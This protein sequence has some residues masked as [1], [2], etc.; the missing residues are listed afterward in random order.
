M[1]KGYLLIFDEAEPALGWRL[2]W[3][4]L[5]GPLLYYASGKFADVQVRLQP[6]VRA[7]QGSPRAPLG[8]PSGSP[9]SLGAWCC[10]Q[11]TPSHDSRDYADYVS[12]AGSSYAPCSEPHV[13][14]PQVSAA[15]R[16][17]GSLT[18]GV[19]SAR[20][21]G[22]HSAAWRG[23]RSYSRLMG[24]QWQYEDPPR[25]NAPCAADQPSPAKPSLFG[26]MPCH[27]NAT[28]APAPSDRADRAG[29]RVGAFAW[30]PLFCCS[31]ARH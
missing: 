18:V 11:F 28:R 26:A 27:R 12:P 9:C 25:I 5:R 13:P 6:S 30:L 17:H 29:W 7:S 24:A 23:V 3:A 4:S 1:K 31:S 15:N 20:A 22:D 14:A 19:L 10:V 2:V 8:L 21:F 16:R